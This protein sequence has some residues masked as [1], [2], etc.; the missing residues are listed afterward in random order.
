M[1]MDGKY[2]EPSEILFCQ[3]LDINWLLSQN[4]SEKRISFNNLYC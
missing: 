2:G 3:V 4:C 1:S